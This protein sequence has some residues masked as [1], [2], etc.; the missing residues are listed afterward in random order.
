MR[1]TALLR[2]QEEGPQGSVASGREHRLGWDGWERLRC[3]I[4][5]SERRGLEH[6]ARTPALRFSSRALATA[7]SWRARCVSHPPVTFSGQSP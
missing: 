3:R 7:D 5:T 4:P 1:S 2:A 6:S